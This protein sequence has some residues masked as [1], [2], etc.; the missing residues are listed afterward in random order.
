[1]LLAEDCPPVHA[2]EHSPGGG[3]DGCGDAGGAALRSIWHTHLANARHATVSHSEFE[4]YPM[5]VQSS[6]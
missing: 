6:T 4:L 1:L 2:F 5:M 3:D